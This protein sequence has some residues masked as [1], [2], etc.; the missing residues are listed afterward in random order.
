MQQLT[1]MDAAFLYLENETTHA[2]GTLVWI[3]DASES[4]PGSITRKALLDHMRARLHISP[5]FTRK[6]E[7]LPLDFDYPYWVDDTA[8]ELLYHIRE[9]SL[10]TAPSWVDFCE[11]V[12]EVHAQPLNHQHPLWELTLVP[13][14][15]GIEGLPQRCFAILGKFHHVAIDGA[16]GMHIINGIH[17]IPGRPAPE[18]TVAIRAARSPALGESLYRAAIS[19]LGA[20]DKGLGLLGLSRSP[21]AEDQPAAAEDSNTVVPEAEDAS[22]L[23]QTIFNR[24]I[25]AKATWDSRSFDLTAIKGMRT[26]VKDATVN[27]VLLAIVGGGLRHYLE[28]R[29]A[30]PENPMRAGCPINI[31]TEEEAG[32]GGNMI[33]AMIVSMH[34]DIAPP[35]QRLRAITRSSAAAKHRAEQRGSRKILDVASVVPAQAQAL[36]GQLAGKV[37]SKLNRAIQFNCSVSN[38]PGPQQ[39]LYMLGGRLQNIAAAMPI[40][41]GYGLFVGLTTCAGRLNISMSSCDSILPDPEKLGDCMEQSYRE[42]LAATRKRPAAKKPTAGRGKSRK[43]APRI[44][45][46]KTR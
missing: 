39:D 21:K 31:R 10:S 37:S 35:L 30:L 15:D 4:A 18:S 6:V 12:A 25:T 3:Y 27:D 32:A 33:S 46:R 42:L 44:Q 16:T 1:P 20:L 45:N 13:G 29:A 11:L 34:T 41:N 40:M 28:Y 26:A 2:H 24:A 23:P 22:P 43:A 36:L 5:V 8:F 19:N 9:R 17:D 14:L 38:L 7:R